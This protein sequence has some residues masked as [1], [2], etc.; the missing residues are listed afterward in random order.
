M[1]V[2]TQPIIVSTISHLA[3]SEM[4]LR[5]LCLVCNRWGE[6]IP[7]VWLDAGKP[8]VNYVE[9]KF[10]CSQCGKRSEKLG[11]CA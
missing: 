2:T 6:I 4:K 8:D 3:R 1:T 9:Q 7:Q 11:V 10:I 5:L